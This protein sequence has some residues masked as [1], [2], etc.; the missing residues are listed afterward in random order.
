MTM[1][2]VDE[3]RSPDVGAVLSAII[4][5]EDTGRV[6]DLRRRVREAM[7]QPH[8]TW[9]CPARIDEALMDKPLAVRKAHAIDLKLRGMPTDLWDGQLLAG[10]MTLDRPRIHYERGFPDY[11]TDEERETARREGLGISSVFGH[12][13]PDY[14]RLLSRGL[15]GIMAGA[16]AQRAGCRSDEEIAFLDSVVIA[17]GAVIAYAARLA[18]RCEEE[19]QAAAGEVRAAEL[20]HMA[21]NLRQVPAGPAET[22][23]QALQSVWLLHMVF[24]ATMNGNA[25]GR[26]DQYVWPYLEADLAAGRTTLEEAAELV[27]CFSLKFNERAAATEEQAPDHREEES[28]DPTARTRHT[29]SSQLGT[30]R[31]RLDATNHWL[32]N[33]VAGGLTPAGE[34]GTNALTYLLLE[35]YH[36]NRMTNPLLTVRLHRNSPEELV[37]YTCEVLKEGGGMPALF[38]DEQL[39]PA[40]EAIGIPTPD[41]RDYT[42]DGCWEVIIPGRTDFGFQRLSMMLCLE[43]ALNRGVSRVSG[44]MN[45]IDTGDPRTFGGWDDVWGAF[46]AQMEHMVGTVVQRVAATID[47][48]A[49]IAPVPLLSALIDGAVEQRRDMTAGGA[50]FRTFGMLAEGAAHAIDSLAAI[51]RVICEEQAATVAEL[52]DALDANYSGYEALRARLDAA[53]KYGND[54]PYADAVGQALIEAFTDCV[55][56][57]ASRHADTL[58]FPAGVGT[59]SWYVAIGEGLGASPDGRLAGQPVSSN[60]SPALGRDLNGL[61]GAVLSYASMHKG[62]LPAGGPLDLR[63]NRRLVEGDEGTGRMAGLVRAFVETGGNMLTL[64]VADTEELRAAQSE[65]EEYRSLRVRMG[66]WCAY[67]TML[68]RE[69]QDHHIRRQEG[70]S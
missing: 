62:N 57:H 49:S 33:I 36:R 30:R 63:M 16:D 18:A 21:A 32:Q 59:F 17:C 52:C 34:D 38:N 23:W 53:P 12:I 31:D 25:L 40:L 45:G 13:V 7:E 35:S 24:H 5:R 39:I 55:A 10:S 54:D 19:A 43:W 68:S 56:R 1:Q 58:A 8:E 20:E 69:Q 2:R 9:R 47:R 46:C 44:G 51:Q 15:R 11:V 14:P 3:R 60:F 61:P 27:D 29:T 41:A 65:P 50:R 6:A 70:R 67:F 28:L 37:R 42:N 4:G 64:T 48:R 66:G 26:L 22:F